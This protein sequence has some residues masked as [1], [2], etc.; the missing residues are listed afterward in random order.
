[1]KKLITLLLIMQTLTTMAQSLQTSNAMVLRID[2]V[3]VT[4]QKL[5]AVRDRQ[6]AQGKTTMANAIATFEAV[7]REALKAAAG[8]SK[9]F[10]VSDMDAARRMERELQTEMA[11]DLS[12]AD[13]EKLRNEMAHKALLVD[14]V[15]QCDITNCQFTRKGN[16]GWTCIL[17]ITPIVRDR[18]SETLRIIA[19]RPF[20]SKIKKMVIRPTREDAYNEALSTMKED[21]V[22]WFTGTFPVYARIMRLDEA[23]NAVIDCGTMHNVE[24]GDIFQVTHIDRQ[25]NDDGKTFDTETVVGTLRAKDVLIDQ[26][27]CSI[28]SGKDEIIN[29]NANGAVLQCKMIMK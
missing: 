5:L 10:D 21:L 6:L 11:M 26:T 16:Y 14:W 4:D 29:L 19:S 27:A 12:A 24:R 3:C 8:A 2:S 13:R 22:E 17:H 1:M 23:N 9:R 28:T 15:L 7:T 20:V 25:I 18:R